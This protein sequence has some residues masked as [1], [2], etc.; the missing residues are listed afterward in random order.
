[1]EMEMPLLRLEAVQ[2][3]KTQKYFLEIYFAF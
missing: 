1:M 2:D 3:P